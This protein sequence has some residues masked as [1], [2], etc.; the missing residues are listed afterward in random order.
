MIKICFQKGINFKDLIWIIIFDLLKDFI[1]LAKK[2]YYNN[3]HERN[4]GNLSYRLKQRRN[5]R[6]KKIF[7]L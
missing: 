1:E 3:W 7:K 4:G 2:G 5:R 6:S